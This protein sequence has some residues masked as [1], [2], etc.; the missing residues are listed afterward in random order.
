LKHAA[1]CNCGTCQG[2][3]IARAKIAASKQLALIRATAP[4]PEPTAVLGKR[5]EKAERAKQSIQAE[6]AATD[7]KLELQRAADARAA[8]DVRATRL[9][10]LALSGVPLAKALEIIE[11]E[12]QEPKPPTESENP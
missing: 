4:R 5:L 10:H 11:S 7:A 6:V 1:G 2:G 3:R 9:M 12:E 8:S